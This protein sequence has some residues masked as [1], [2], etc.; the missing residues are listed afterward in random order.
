ML[1]TQTVQEFRPEFTDGVI[2]LIV[3]IQREEFGVPITAD[4]QPDLKTI[5]AFYQHGTGNFWIAT[6]DGRLVGT[7]ALKDI[8]NR[9]AALRKMFVAPEA[10]GKDKGIALALLTA[11][12]DWAKQRGVKEVYL[13]TTDKFKAAHRFYEKNGFD[14]IP[15][16]ALPAAFPRMIQD[17]KYYR[18]TL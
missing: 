10:R 8:G 4:E 17:T 9:Q 6:L 7:I 3:G 15:P 2:S 16:E 11:L 14:E 5:P 12:L 13:G 18:R 1:Q